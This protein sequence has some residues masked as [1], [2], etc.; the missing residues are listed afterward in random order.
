MLNTYTQWH[1]NTSNAGACCFVFI[2]ESDWNNF[3]RTRQIWRVKESRWYWVII[4]VCK[5]AEVFID[6]RSAYC[7]ALCRSLNITVFAEIS[8]SISGSFPKKKILIGKRFYTCGEIAVTL[9]YFKRFNK[10]F[11]LKLQRDL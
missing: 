7:K 8:K 11:L 6:G 10:Y 9:Q 2:Y 4:A 1:W 5:Y 3:S